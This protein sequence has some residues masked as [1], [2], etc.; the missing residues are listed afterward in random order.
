MAHERIAPAM[1][2]NIHV[3]RVHAQRLMTPE[4]A[5]AVAQE[6]IRVLDAWSR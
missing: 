2:Q 1:R 6:L 4:G 5:A 3:E